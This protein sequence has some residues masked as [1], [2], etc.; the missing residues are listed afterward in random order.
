MGIGLIAYSLLLKGFHMAKQPTISDTM[1]EAGI[2]A[3]LIYNPTYILHSEQLKDHHFYNKDTACMYWG[4]QQLAHQGV[5]NIDSLNLTTIINSNEGIKNTFD[6]FGINLDE[7]IDLSKNIARDSLEE[8][9]L[10]V[11]RVMALSYKRELHKYLK[12]YDTMCL[13]VDQDDITNISNDLYT[14]LN[15]L[16]EQY[17]I[18]A[19]EIQSMGEII[20]D[21]WKEI[22]DDGENSESNYCSKLEGLHDY[23]SYTPKSV[24]LWAARY[25][26]GKSCLALNEVL[27]LAPKGAVIGYFDSEIDTKE[28]TIRCLANLANVTFAKIKY[29]KYNQEERKR[30]LEA[31]K[32]F[33]S[34]NIVH[35]YDTNWTPEKIVSTSKVL[36]AKYGMDFLVFDYLKCTDGLNASETYLR[37]GNLAN[38]LKNNVAGELDIPVITLAQLNRNNEIADSDAIARY[39][40]TIIYWREKRS[41][42]I[43]GDWR[44]F[45]N[46]KLQV[47]DNRSG[48]NMNDDEWLHCVFDGDIMTIT[49]APT[50]PKNDN[51]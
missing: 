34:K 6:K 4:I 21:L 5:D 22:Q 19:S 24:T 13:D 37:L 49:Q 15:K 45:G 8:Y 25:K 17:I 23:F 42:E 3:S 7:Y 11:N 39:V 20:D 30:L 47:R 43:P 50:Q 29:K 41:D 16:S 2:I 44:E 32:W 36:R 27:N 28:F 9:K 1:A 46:Y 51:L 12:K 14:T 31:V 10:L 38:T 18:G 33:K 48:S 35:R 40:S 26:Q